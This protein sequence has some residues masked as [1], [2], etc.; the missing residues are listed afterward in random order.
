[1]SELRGKLQ[2][3]AVQLGMHVWHGIGMGAA[4]GWARASAALPTGALLLPQLASFLHSTVV[5]L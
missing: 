2:F 1:M 3:G 4:M 5:R